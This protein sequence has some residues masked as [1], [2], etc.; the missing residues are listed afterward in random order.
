MATSATRR[1]LHIEEPHLSAI[2]ER[3]LAFETSGDLSYFQTKNGFWGGKNSFGDIS[4]FSSYD[5]IVRYNRIHFKDAIV[6]LPSG[7]A[8]ATSGDGIQDEW[9]ASRIPGSINI[10]GRAGIHATFDDPSFG[11]LS[12]SSMI[13]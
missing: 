2:N 13:T 4:R 11:N 7:D 9:G 1:I 5:D 8:Q 3:Q 10:G 6:L 12:Y